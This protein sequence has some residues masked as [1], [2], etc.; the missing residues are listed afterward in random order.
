M[1]RDAPRPDRREPLARLLGKSAISGDSIVVGPKGPF[2]QSIILHRSGR[3]AAFGSSSSPA[4][5]PGGQVAESARSPDLSFPATAP[6]ARGDEQFENG[7][8][9][10]NI[11]LVVM[12]N[13]S[14]FE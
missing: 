6:V 4:W 9:S 10:C 14:M 2:P 12:L 3:A 8:T 11:A 5:D 13:Q 7:V 1:I